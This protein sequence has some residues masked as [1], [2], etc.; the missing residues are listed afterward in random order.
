MPQHIEA[1]Y[2]EILNEY[3]KKQT[4]QNLYVG[5]NF[6]RQLILENISPEEVISMHKAAIREL[7]SDLPDVVWHSFDF[8]IEMMINYGLALQERQSLLKRQEELKVEMDLAA[9]VQ[10]TLLKTKLPSLDGLDIGLLSIPAKKMNG[11]YI[12]FVSDYDGYAGVAVADVI[13]KGLPAALC[14]SMIKFGMD[15][16]NSS[17][18]MPKDVLSVINRIV[19]KS[20]DDSMF[21]SMFYANYDASAAKLTYGSA[22]HEPAILYRA[23]TGGFDEL[24]AKGLL[25]GVSPAA[26]YEEHSVTLGK[27]D[28]VI[29]M[30]DGVTEG[31]T[32]EGFIERDV[33]YE[34]IEQ[35]KDEP[36]QAIVQH[37]Y[38]EL[39]RMQNAELQDDFTLVIYKKV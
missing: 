37:V 15:S 22:G 39:E 32:E 24:E 8:L 6:S 17:H 36:A 38:D 25:L 13:G 19:E 33:I 30:T 21:V 3:V 26:V 23:N 31:R 18:A 35:K 10:E 7:Y 2:Q 16:L 9:N 20:V 11:D 12:Y 27:G 29:M 14:M 5:Q 28:M 34:L 4:E 1:Q